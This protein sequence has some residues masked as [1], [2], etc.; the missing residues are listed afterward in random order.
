MTT[1]HNNGFRTM[2]NYYNLSLCGSMEGDFVLLTCLLCH[3]WYAILIANTHK[4]VYIDAIVFEK[5]MERLS[6]EILLDYWAK[7]KLLNG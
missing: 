4:D 1:T 5:L 3:V 7:E 6:F 2:G